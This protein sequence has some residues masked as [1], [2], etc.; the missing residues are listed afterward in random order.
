MNRMN[1]VIKHCKLILQKFIL[2]KTLRNCFSNL[3]KS[4]LYFTV[5]DCR[6]L[7]SG[8][9]SDWENR[10]SLGFSVDDCVIIF[11]GVIERSQALGDVTIVI[12]FSLR[13]ANCLLKWRRPPWQL[14]ELLHAQVYLY[15]DIVHWQG[16]EN[17]TEQITSKILGSRLCLTLLT[18]SLLTW[19]PCP[20]F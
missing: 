7:P 14:R 3:H 16:C 11:V 5:F 6:R 18:H 17:Q 8:S 1:L 19:L 20:A 15:N 10:W 2:W 4:C 13:Q 12:F 9:M